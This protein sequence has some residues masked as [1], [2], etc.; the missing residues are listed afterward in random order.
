MTNEG[1]HKIVID[2]IATALRRAVDSKSRTRRMSYKAVPF[3]NRLT[4]K[5]VA[6]AEVM[7]PIM[8][9]LISCQAGFDTLVD[10]IIN[11][12]IQPLLDGLD[13]HMNKPVID[14][15]AQWED[16][17]E[18]VIMLVWAT[19]KSHGLQVEYDHDS[20]IVYT[21]ETRFGI[22]SHRIMSR[23]NE[24][25][26]VP[27]KSP[28]RL[29][30]SDRMIRTFSARNIAMYREAY[31]DSEAATN[32]LVALL[33]AWPKM[34]LWKKIRVAKVVEL[35]SIASLHRWERI[36]MNQNEPVLMLYRVIVPGWMSRADFCKVFCKPH[37]SEVI[38]FELRQQMIS[39]MY[40][41]FYKNK[42]TKK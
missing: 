2:E 31:R 26:V 8:P 30:N 41:H 36:I 19:A 17:S 35:P 15:L 18:K 16:A 37:T 40:R 10:N 25:T 42:E 27:I 34:D 38:G 24:G 5:G 3:D 1:N 23:F 28:K 4:Y 12:D 14:W 7:V 39:R 13:L 22:A 32:A 20:I 33:T 11:S 6:L 29:L 21:G 9:D